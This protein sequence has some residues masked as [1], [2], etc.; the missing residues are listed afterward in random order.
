MYLS[1]SVSLLMRRKIRMVV[2]AMTL[3]LSVLAGVMSAQSGQLLPQP[4]D[5]VRVNVAVRVMYSPRN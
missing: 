5:D 2:F 4:D 1:D 3:A